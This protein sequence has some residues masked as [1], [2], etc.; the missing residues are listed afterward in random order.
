MTDRRYAKLAQPQWATLL[1]AIRA[2]E[3]KYHEC[4]I[5]ADCRICQ[6]RGECAALALA[7]TEEVNT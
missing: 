4:G 7:K 2:H 5:D 3:A 6:T 1:N